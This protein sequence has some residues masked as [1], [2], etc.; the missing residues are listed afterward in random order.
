MKKL[1]N[2]TPPA[3][4][5][6]EYPTPI[7][8]VDVALF[9]I[10]PGDGLKVLVITRERDPY[11]GARAL[12]GG[13]VRIDEDENTDDTAK[14]I[15]A[16]KARL[17]HGCYMEQ[18]YTFS[19]RV[20]DPRGWSLSVAYYAVAAAD[21][22]EPESGAAWVEVDALPELPFDH[23]RIVTKAVERLRNKSAYSTLPAY[24]LP[25]AFTL[26]ELR[27]MYESVLRTD[28]ERM[29]FRKKMEDQDIVEP[30]EG[31]R[32]GN[33]N[34]PAQLYRLRHRTLRE[35]DRSLRRT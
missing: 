2:T 6:P 15:L 28:L 4:A 23:A 31:K 9:T 14:R 3:S 13:Y 34:R 24:L 26:E 5:A 20:R 17:R 11:G 12:P 10:G 22:V 1:K 32:R 18:L 27:L 21:S 25:E 19:G 16:D 8:T 7:A 30:V 29:S 33:A 35:F